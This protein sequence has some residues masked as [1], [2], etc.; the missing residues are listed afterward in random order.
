MPHEPL[1]FEDSPETQVQQLDE[2]AINLGIL[3]AHSLQNFPDLT[4]DQFRSEIHLV[5]HFSLKAS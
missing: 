3:I 5:I 4:P 1:D 2:M